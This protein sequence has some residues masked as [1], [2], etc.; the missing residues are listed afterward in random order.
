MNLDWIN[1]LIEEI[2]N[3]KSDKKELRKFGITVGVVLILVGFLFQLVWDSYTAYM[4][5][6]TIGAVLLF[7]GIIY[8][9]LLLPIQKIWMTLAVLLGFI[10]TRV[11]LTLLF[12]FVVS[13]VGLIA[14]LVGKDFIGSKID[15]DKKSYWNKRDKISYSKE[16]TERQF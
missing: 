1:L 3:I 6:G 14:K 2:K 5:I 12:Y 15:R 4:I 10:M 13:I 9:K 8:P 7:F 11:I 16:L